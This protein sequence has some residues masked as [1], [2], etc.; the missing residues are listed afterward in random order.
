MKGPY[1]DILTLPHHVSN[2]RAH[3]PRIDRAAQFAPFSA[4][5]GYSDKIKETSRIVDKQIDLD[6]EDKCIINKKILLLNDNIKNNTQVSI[7]YFIK[8]N[9]KD[10]GSYI[11]T[12]DIIKKIDMYNKLIILISGIKIL[13]DDIYNIESNLFDNI[14]SD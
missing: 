3:M 11:T 14:L 13:F 6:E 12:F 1:D 7:T 8:D 5:A 10:G 2:K 9:I 4:L